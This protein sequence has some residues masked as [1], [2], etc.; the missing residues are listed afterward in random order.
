M[1][2]LG[3]SFMRNLSGVFWVFGFGGFTVCRGFR[4]NSGRA[5]EATIR[6]LQGVQSV[7]CSAEA[8]GVVSNLICVLQLF[9]M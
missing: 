9:P 2:P 8:W 4:I 3:N 5:L 1:D 6:A 7:E